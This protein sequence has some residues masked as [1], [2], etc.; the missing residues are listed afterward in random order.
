MAAQIPTKGT[1]DQ[2]VH[3]IY[4]GTALHVVREFS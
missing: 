2:L 1:I 4:H 3:Y